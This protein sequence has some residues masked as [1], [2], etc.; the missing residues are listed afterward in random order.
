MSFWTIILAI[1]VGL[2]AFVILFTIYALLQPNPTKKELEETS[3]KIKAKMN[4]D[5]KR[6][7]WLRSP[8]NPA[9]M[10]YPFNLITSNK[11]PK[12]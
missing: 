3:A 11:P 12:S 6:V 10:V 4:V 9:N 7:A 5:P 8:K 2:I 1:V